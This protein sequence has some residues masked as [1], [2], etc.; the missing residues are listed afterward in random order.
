VQVSLALLISSNENR[1]INYS[2]TIVN[3]VSVGTP[4]DFVERNEIFGFFTRQ[5]VLV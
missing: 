5:I 3:P 4:K 2:V 1:L